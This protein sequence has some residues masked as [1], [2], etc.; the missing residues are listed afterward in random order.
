MTIYYNPDPMHEL[1]G[2]GAKVTIM[3][4]NTWHIK[5]IGI[6]G[7]VVRVKQYGS[8]SYSV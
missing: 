4:Y 5:L 7:R 1:E 8:M 6:C 3:Q 2:V